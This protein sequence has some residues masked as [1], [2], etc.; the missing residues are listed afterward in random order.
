MTVC[1]DCLELAS[2]LKN[3]PPH[4]ALKETGSA[5]LGRVSR[6]MAA[7]FV[8]HYECQTCGTQIS[9]DGDTKDA[10]AGWYIV[11]KG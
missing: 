10:G 6:G 2:K 11:R 4:S 1:K 3:E 5:R 9:C 7:G 8:T